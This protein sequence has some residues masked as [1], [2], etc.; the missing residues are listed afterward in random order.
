MKFI[1]RAAAAVLVGWAIIRLAGA[2]RVHRVEAPVA[3]LLSFTPFIAAAAP[4]VTLLQRR[5]CGAVAAALAGSALAA[6][7]MPRAIKR[8]QPDARGPILRVLTANLLAG[9]ASEDAV[10]DLVWRSRAD[11][12]FVQELTDDAT[13][14]LKQAGLND[15]LPHS[16]TDASSAGPCGSGIYT[17][18]PLSDGPAI[19]PISVAQ[20]T[21]RM[22]LPAGQVVDL[23]CVHP[24]PPTPVTSRRKAARWRKELSVLPRPA[25]VPRVLAGDFNATFDHSHFRRL[26]RLGYADAAA[27][28]GKGLVPTW[29]PKGKPALLTIDHVLLDA[30]CAV[31]QVSVHTLPG[32]DHRAVF[33]EFRLPGG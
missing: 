7:V 26:L 32:T 5:R 30:R 6:V 21:A 9:R 17:R 3:P 15:L 4:A 18:F 25:E 23:V 2:D 24:Q 20:P 8:Q 28:K 27:Q 31:L 19:K 12:L 22:E 10:V 13:S 1:S 11:V 33:T 29:G 14:R 16:V